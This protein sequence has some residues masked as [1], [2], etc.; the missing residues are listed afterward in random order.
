MGTIKKNIDS[1]H[2]RTTAEF[3]RDMMLMFT[4]AIMYNSSGHN[5]NQMAQVM[6][7]DVMK[8]I[9]MMMQTTT[10]SKNLRQ[11]RR[12][13]AVDHK[14]DDPKKNRDRRQS[15]DHA[16]GGKAKKRKRIDDA[17]S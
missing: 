15:V 8:H 17:L 7:D 9:E 14:E 3:Q 10:D 4:N 5:V 13:D 1:G 16:E 6:Y 2:L 12:S 11:S